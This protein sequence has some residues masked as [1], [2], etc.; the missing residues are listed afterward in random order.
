MNIEVHT[1]LL[2]QQQENN[3]QSV[4]HSQNKQIALKDKTRKKNFNV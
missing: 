3:N 4:I 2:F 1:I